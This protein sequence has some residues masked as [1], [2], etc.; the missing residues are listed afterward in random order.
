MILNIGIA[1]FKIFPAFL[2]SLFKNAVM[3][4]RSSFF[5][6]KP[7]HPGRLGADQTQ[8]GERFSFLLNFPLRNFTLNALS[9]PAQTTPS[10]SG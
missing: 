8:A 4:P 3:R 9:P 2:A 1:Q 10:S 5:L 7:R 6:Q